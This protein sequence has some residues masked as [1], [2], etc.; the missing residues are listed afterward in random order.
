MRFGAF[1]PQGWRMELVG[2]PHEEQWPT[3]MRVAGEI[4][5]LGYESAWV[6]DHFHNV[7]DPSTQESTFEAWSVMAGLAAATKNIRL[8]QMCTCNGYRPP[9]YMAKVAATVD[10][11]SGGRLEFSIGAGWYE[12]EY[13]AY[14][15]PFPSGGTRIAEL[16]E[17]IQIIKKMWTED[18]AT[19]KGEHFSIDAAICQPK[20]LQDPHPPVW[21]AGGGERKTLRVVAEHADYSNFGSDPEHFAHKSKVLEGHCEAIGRDYSTIGRTAILHA[22]IGRT[23]AEVDAKVTRVAAQMGVEEERVRS[24]MAC[25]TS[26]VVVDRLGRLR[27]L[28]CVHI[29]TYFPDVVW[30]DGMAVFA[31]EVIPA[32]T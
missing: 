10:V 16:N 6:Y 15:Y 8:G 20:P 29:Q 12:H 17:S 3:I 7:P 22:V 4:E 25:G 32:L 27:D 19:F 2:V 30:G 31:N 28:G 9:A 14:G 21:I 26:D 18:E 13:L 24:G 1:V 23:E 5:E 11:M